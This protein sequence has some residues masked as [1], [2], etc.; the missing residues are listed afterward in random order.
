MASESDLSLAHLQAEL[1][2]FE[3]RIQREVLRAGQDAQYALR[4][5]QISDA[6]ALRLVEGNPGP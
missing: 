4:G 1:G 5:L 2:R 6:E 3:V